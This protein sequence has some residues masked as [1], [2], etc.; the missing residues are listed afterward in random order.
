MG[1]KKPQ[2]THFCVGCGFFLCFKHFVNS[3]VRFFLFEQV[4]EL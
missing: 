1:K 2:S 3:C 4:E